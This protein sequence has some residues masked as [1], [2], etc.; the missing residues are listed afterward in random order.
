MPIRA[1]SSEERRAYAEIARALRRLRRVQ[2]LKRKPAAGPKRGK[3]G[4]G[5]GG[6]PQ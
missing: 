2:M 4:R 1:V 6:P 3:A 5:E